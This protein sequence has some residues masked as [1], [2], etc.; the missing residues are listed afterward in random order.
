MLTSRVVVVGAAEPPSAAPQFG[1]H[2]HGDRLAPIGAHPHTQPARHSHPVAQPRHTDPCQH[3]SGGLARGQHRDGIGMGPGTRDL[4]PFCRYGRPCGTAAPFTEMFWPQTDTVSMPKVMLSACSAMVSAMVTPP[5]AAPCHGVKPVTP[6]S[7]WPGSPS[8]PPTQPC[9]YPV[10]A[11]SDGDG[12]GAIGGSSQGV[13]A[14]AGE[15]EVPPVKGA[16]PGAGPGQAGG[17]GA[18]V[19]GGCSS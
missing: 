2:C 14:L 8:S 16:V 1:V 17:R 7:D 18:P 13:D 3:H 10:L 4:S 11:S 9:G 12:P 15:V 19:P 6:Q 5:Q